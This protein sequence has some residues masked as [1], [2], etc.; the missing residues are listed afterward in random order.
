MTTTIASMFVLVRRL[1]ATPQLMPTEPRVRAVLAM[2]SKSTM[3]AV[4]KA[5]ALEDI[6]IFRAVH[7]S[8][9]LYPSDAISLERLTE[10]MVAH[11]RPPDILWRRCAQFHSKPRGAPRRPGKGKE[12]L[13]IQGRQGACKR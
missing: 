11:A 6:A 8:T 5:L 12:G 4:S 10:T 13:P 9:V 7:S 2:L 1:R 3:P